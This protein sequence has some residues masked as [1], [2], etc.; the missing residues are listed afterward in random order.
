MTNSRLPVS[1][2][3][4]PHPRLAER[5]RVHSMHPWRQ[6]IRAHSRE[7]FERADDLI[8]Q[9]PKPVILDSG[10]GNGWGAA[11]LA[12]RFPD[13]WVV[14][15]DRSEARL[16]KASKAAEN[17]Q[18]IRANLEDFWRLI[19]DSQWLVERHYVLY[20]NPYP[21]AIH[22]QRRW[23]GHPVWHTLLRVSP[24]LIMRTNSAIY[25]LE[26]W[27]ALLYCGC[28]TAQKNAL[29]F[30]HVQSQPMTAFEKKYA[31]SGH[32]LFEVTTF[33]ECH[34]DVNL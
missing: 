25:A 28:H 2:Q 16:G 5:L 30:D 19:V 17:L 10:C 27:Q 9:N 34:E 31:M 12:Q 7:A 6:P 8:K 4:E 33:G 11:Q 29:E 18:F 32:L 24:N 20:P 23:H 21:K 3:T 26:W 13:H 15:V 1:N 14:G 22:L